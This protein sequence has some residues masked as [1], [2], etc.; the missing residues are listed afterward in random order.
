MLEGFHIGEYIAQ[1]AVVVRHQRRSLLILLQQ[2]LGEAGHVHKAFRLHA[3]LDPF[4][5]GVVG[6]HLLIAL[7]CGCHRLKQRIQ[8]RFKLLLLALE[9]VPLGFQSF[10]LALEIAHLLGKLGFLG[11]CRPVLRLG[12]VQLSF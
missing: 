12:A 5:L 1:D 8:I 3:L 4:Q 9:T 10:G 2:S 6:Y 11:F 7:L